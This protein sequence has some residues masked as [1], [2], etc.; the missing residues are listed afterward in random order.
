MIPEYLQA[1]PYVA[2]EGAPVALARL[3]LDEGV[4]MDSVRVGVLRAQD[5]T[6]FHPVTARGYTQWSETVAYLRQSL[7][8][9]QWTRQDPQNS[10]RVFSP[11]GMTSV[12]VAGGNADTGVTLERN[13]RMARRRGPMTRDAVQCNGQQMLNVS[14]E[15]PSTRASQGPFTWVLLYHWSKDEPTVRAELSLP[16]PGAVTDDGDISS[17]SHRILLPP[18]DLTGI[19]TP[20][21]PVGPQDDVD[22]RIVELS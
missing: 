19:D 16:V 6:D 4:L 18:Q 21:R 7:F 1:Q 5:V 10:P 22:F 11:D 14:L 17:W 20:Q 12:M 13:P 3:G 8:E 15:L 9:R 2:A